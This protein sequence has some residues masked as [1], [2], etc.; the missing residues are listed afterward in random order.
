MTQ[1]AQET[2]LVPTELGGEGRSFAERQL[3][4]GAE[5]PVQSV[6]EGARIPTQHPDPHR[7]IPQFLTNPR[8]ALTKH[9]R[10]QVLFI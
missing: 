10:I 3:S 4:Q 9:V 2:R 5:A 6:P 8:Q 1:L 7:Q